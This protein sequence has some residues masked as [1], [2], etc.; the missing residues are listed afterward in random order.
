MHLAVGVVN[1]RLDTKGQAE[2]LKGVDGVRRYRDQA[3]DAV[4]LR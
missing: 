4:Y 1:L 2:V 3:S